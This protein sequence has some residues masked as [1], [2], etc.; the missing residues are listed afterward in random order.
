MSAPQAA[1]RRTDFGA[2]LRSQ[3]IGLL[4]SL[5]AILAGFS[6]GG[7]FGAWEE[8]LEADLFH[9]AQKVLDKHYGGD[10][11]AAQRTVDRA[12]AYYQRAHM[13]WGGIGAAT[14]AASLLLAGCLGA[15]PAGRLASLAMGLG[16]L[17]YPGYWLVAGRRAPGLG[18]TGAAKASLQWLAVPSA[19]LLLLGAAA[20][21]V[22]VAARLFGRQPD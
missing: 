9:S 4:L 15:S 3:R 21:L 18:G 14:L 22:L 13:H 2:G 12:F 19:G 6:L 11:A 1:S 5:L 10:E 16:A 17:L 7:V 20:A 8:R